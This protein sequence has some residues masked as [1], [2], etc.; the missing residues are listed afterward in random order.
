[1]ITVA[2]GDETSTFG[3]FSSIPWTSGSFY[4]KIEIDPQGG[5]NYTSMGSTK[6]HSVPFAL[7]A[8]AVPEEYLNTDNQTLS[9]NNNQLS[10]SNG[11]TVNISGGYS[12]WAADGSDISYTTGKVGIGVSKPNSGLEVQGLQEFTSTDTLFLVKDKNGLPVF[13]VF[14]DGVEIYVDDASKGNVGGF[15]VSGRSAS[16]ASYN[17]FLDL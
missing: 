16:K 3:N 15:A 5:S 17:K 1:L 14:E 2:I 7:F 12:P 4:I 9:I 10:I 13:A 8:S 11:N 6:L